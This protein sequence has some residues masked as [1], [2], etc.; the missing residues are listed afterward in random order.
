MEFA[1]IIFPPRPPTEKEVKELM[2]DFS[3]TGLLDSGYLKVMGKENGNYNCLGWALQKCCFIMDDKYFDGLNETVSL[4]D[5]YGFEPTAQMELADI[6]VWG[7]SDEE[8]GNCR[9]HPPL[10]PKDG[11][12]LDK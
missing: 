11:V 10:R 4:M 3:D 7:S 9:I 5:R 1:G 8:T 6:D 2:V 12:W